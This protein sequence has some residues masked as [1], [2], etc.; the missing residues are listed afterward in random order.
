MSLTE[1]K[2]NKML[3]NIIKD[4]LQQGIAITASEVLQELSDLVEEVN[5]TDKHFDLSAAKVTMREAASASKYNSAIDQ[6]YRDL[7]D[8]YDTIS[9]VSQKRAIN[10]ER[11]KMKLIETSRKVGALRSSLNGLLL[12]KKDTAGYFDMIEDY[13]EDLNKINMVDSTVSI[14]V[15]NHTMTIPVDTKSQTLINLNNLF[16]EDVTFNVLTRQNLLSYNVVPGSSV[17]NAFKDK[18]NAWQHQVYMGSFSEPIDVELKV[19]LAE[20]PITINRIEFISHSSDVN[21][22]ISVQ[23]QFSVD[24][25]NW[26]DISFFNNPQVITA[27]G[28]FD[29]ESIDAKYVK[30][31][32]TKDA[33]DDTDGSNYVYEFGAKNISFFSRS[34]SLLSGEFISTPLSVLEDDGETKKQFN[35]LSCE[36]C[37]ILPEGTDIEY[38][39]SN[40]GAT[41][42]AGITPLNRVDAPYPKIFNVGGSTIGESGT[43]V[44]LDLITSY[45]YKNTNDRLLDYTIGTFTYEVPYEHIKVLRD[46]GQ[47]DDVLT[48]GVISGWQ[49]DDPY[50]TTHVNIENTGGVYIELG[51]TQAEIDSQVVTGTVF[52]DG[53]QHKFKTH[54]SNWKKLSSDFDPADE[55]EFRAGDQLYPYN[56]KLIVEGV[57]YSGFTSYTGNE[58]YAGVDLYASYIMEFSPLFDFNYNVKSDDYARYS[59][60]S[61]SNILS[62]LVKY[63]NNISD[64][65]QESFYIINK[66]VVNSVDEVLFKAKLSTTNTDSSPIMTGY[67]IKIGN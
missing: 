22:P 63:D 16:A 42:W 13:L 30:F 60:A 59:I 31:I 49:Y 28:F 6:I 14:N 64:F 62:F 41:T 8:V 54:K 39:I 56:H 37:E 48:R 7:E 52:I 10:F 20:E 23:A 47:G 35:V 67:R 51:D 46:V 58:V 44:K 26:Q 15:D 11:W 61:E 19:K 9:S 5:I 32:I 12:L 36:V 18:S 34:Y 24:D 53:G 45:G 25:Y 2:I 40:D 65:G 43:D 21:S 17:L 57:N 33:H 38:F 55:D 3:E 66:N 29:F 50:Y 4:N 27:T 1:T